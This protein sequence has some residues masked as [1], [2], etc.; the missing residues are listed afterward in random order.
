MSNVINV[1]KN[2]IVLLIKLC[3][4]TVYSIIYG[5]AIL[6]KNYHTQQQQQQQK[7]NTTYGVTATY[8]RHR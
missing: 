1:Y 5:I 2:I 7:L 3:Y 6:E 8:K 4:T